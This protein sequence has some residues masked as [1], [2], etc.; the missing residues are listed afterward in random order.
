[1]FV[2]SLAAL[3][4]FGLAERRVPQ[5]LVD[6]VLVGRASVPPASLRLSPF[7]DGLGLRPVGFLAGIRWVV[8]PVSQLARRLRHG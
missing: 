6:L 7:R 5:P 8:Y 3:A 4:A 2:A 1:L